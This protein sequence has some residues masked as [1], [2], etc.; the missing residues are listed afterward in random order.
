MELFAPVDNP[1]G[2][3][4]SPVETVPTEPTHDTTYGTCLPPPETDTSLAP[5]LR[6]NGRLVPNP[7][8][9]YC[10]YFKS[11]LSSPN[12]TTCPTI[13]PDTCVELWDSCPSGTGQLS[14]VVHSKD[15]LGV[16]S[17]MI[18]NSSSPNVNHKDYRECYA[19]GTKFC[20]YPETKLT[21]LPDGTYVCQKDCPAN[22]YADDDMCYVNDPSVS[23]VGLTQSLFCNPQYFTSVFTNGVFQGCKK[24]P[25]GTKDTN[26]CPV[27][28]ETILNDS[29]TAEW[30][31]PK[32]DPKYSPSPN[33]DFCFA[34]C[35]TGN[36]FHDYAS[37]FI[38]TGRCQAGKDC[39]GNMQGRCPVNSALAPN[40]NTYSGYTS[41][42]PPSR[43][44]A[45]TFADTSLH[46]TFRSGL[47][48]PKPG[49]G[50]IECPVGMAAGEPSTGEDSGHCYDTCPSGFARAELCTTSGIVT[51]SG[52]PNCDAKDLRFICIASCPKN[53]SEK[54]I[55]A[56]HQKVYSCAYNYPNGKVPSDPSLFVNCPTN[57]TMI[58]VIMDTTTLPNGSSM[59]PVPPVCLR[60]IFMR[61]V[62][63]PLNHLDI[64][65]ACIQNCPN[66]SIPISKNGTITCTETCPSDSRFSQD[67]SSL[68]NSNLLSNFQDANCIRNSHGTGSGKDPLLISAPTPVADASKIGLVVGIGFVGMFAL[69]F[70]KKF[71]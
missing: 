70:L 41:K 30:C 7:S 37:Y 9:K 60:K 64:N 15:T 67:Y 20:T 47:S 22:T 59:K 53:Y 28:T 42:V 51:T 19:F 3:A 68:Q 71:I 17:Q 11:Q 58:S 43:M 5:C 14:S 27:N 6:I 21:R 16:I 54:S 62:A 2:L 33:L 46:D 26:S 49:T 48:V 69:F 65:G 32:C 63:C 8:A 50:T 4:E 23:P 12:E 52:T 38:K 40:A 1:L 45:Y 10:R 39:P 57:G 36:P 13:C 25:L 18:G 55:D 29:F 66:G 56:K 35:D 61:N 24:I 44:K 34:K 31:I